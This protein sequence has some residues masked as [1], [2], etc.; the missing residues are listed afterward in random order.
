MRTVRR[1]T[2]R[3]HSQ[4]TLGSSIVIPS[5]IS[6]DKAAIRKMRLGDHLATEPSTCSDAGV[7]DRSGALTPHSSQDDIRQAGGVGLAAVALDVHRSQHGDITRDGEYHHVQLYA[8][9]D[10]ATRLRNACPLPPA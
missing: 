3:G 2:G 4:R 7:G 8:N 10:T 9:R 5:L 6:A 1:G